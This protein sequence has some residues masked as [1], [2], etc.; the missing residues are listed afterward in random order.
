M[1]EHW[2]QKQVFN[3]I[4]MAGGSIFFIGTLCLKKSEIGGGE[5]N[6]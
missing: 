5:K 1:T 6:I 2:G 3:T 4:F